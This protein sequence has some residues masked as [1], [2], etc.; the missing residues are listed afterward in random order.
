MR[1]LLALIAYGWLTAGGIL[2]FAVDVVAQAWRGQRLPGP[3][4]TLY[5]GLNTA[6]ACGQLWFGLLGLWLAW[7]VPG[8][9]A[10]WPPLALSVA[11][12]ACWLGIGF[13]FL[14]YREPSYVAAVFLLLAIAA[15]VA[16]NPAEG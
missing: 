4:T 15:M 3:E 5:Y 14:E 1:R 13:F 16:G 11:A 10:Q 2:H 9:L 12:G 8:M 7:R 6:F